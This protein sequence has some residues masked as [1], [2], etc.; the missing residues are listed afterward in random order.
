MFYITVLDLIIE[1]FQLFN[2]QNFSIICQL[3][4]F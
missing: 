2:S 4:K 3:L 1:Q